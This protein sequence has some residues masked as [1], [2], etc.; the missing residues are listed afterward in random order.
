M[1]PAWQRSALH[2]IG[3]HGRR[4]QAGVQIG[5][6]TVSGKNT[7]GLLGE[8]IRFDAGIVGQ[9]DC[10]TRPLTQQIIRQPLCGAADGI[11]VHTV[12]AGADDA[13]QSSGAK[14]QLPIKPVVNLFLVF[15]DTKQFLGEIGILRGVFQPFLI[16]LVNA[17]LPLGHA[18]L[19]IKYD[20][21][22]E[23]PDAVTASAHAPPFSKPVN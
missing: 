18:V 2:R 15:F 17:D 13:T 5:T 23:I 21:K 9:G 14:L 20:L 16:L 10:G 3:Q 7:G 4:F 11:D 6:D 1:I 8:K 19:S 22:K 12:F